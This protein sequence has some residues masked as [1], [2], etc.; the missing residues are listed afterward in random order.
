MFTE[1][2]F[3]TSTTNL[4]KRL[5]NVTLNV[6]RI[7]MKLSHLKW[8]IWP[9]QGCHFQCDGG[10]SITLRSFP[11]SMWQ[12]WPLE[13]LPHPICQV[14][15]PW[16]PPQWLLISIWWVW[17]LLQERFDSCVVVNFFFN[18]FAYWFMCW[19]CVISSPS[20]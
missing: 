15:P 2:R 17:P 6:A 14:W 11:I 13:W 10:F 1:M 16:P 9:P 7:T 3:W 8:W 4:T 18:F 20:A 19:D 12:V 5:Q